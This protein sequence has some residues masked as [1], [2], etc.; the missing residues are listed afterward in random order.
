MMPPQLPETE[1]TPLRAD[2]LEAEA[3]RQIVRRHG[4]KVSL[5]QVLD[6]LLDIGWKP[7]T[8]KAGAKAQSRIVTC[9]SCS[10]RVNPADVGT[11]CRLPADMCPY[12][13]SH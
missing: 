13:H 2:P 9:A 3:Y 7:P 11:V 5:D 12:R 10:A 4:T 6:T 8:V 1:D